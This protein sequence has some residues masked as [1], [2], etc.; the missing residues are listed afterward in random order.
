[1]ET[2]MPL[3]KQFS[4]AGFNALVNSINDVETLREFLIRY[5]TNVVAKDVV[6]DGIMKWACINEV[7]GYSDISRQIIEGLQ[8]DKDSKEGNND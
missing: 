4:I 6:V 1:M 5:H 2:N 7:A 8:K 3:E